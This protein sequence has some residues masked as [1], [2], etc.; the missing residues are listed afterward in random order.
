MASQLF[1]EGSKT[2]RLCYLE[3][4]WGTLRTEPQPKPIRT[5]RKK[6]STP[7]RREYLR[8]KQQESRARRKLLSE[9]E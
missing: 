7:E 5:R 9:K 8:I 6:L 4:Q 2:L 1:S 3:D